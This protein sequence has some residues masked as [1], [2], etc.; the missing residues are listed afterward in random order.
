M[1]VSLT[2]VALLLTV[3]AVAVLVSVIVGA[4][5]GVIARMGGASVPSAV[6]KGGAALGG[7]LALLVSVIALATSL[8]L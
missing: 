8:V 3:L 6:L 4:A 2:L 5:V 7:T 1:N